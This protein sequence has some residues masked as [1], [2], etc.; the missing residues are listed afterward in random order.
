VERCG[1]ESSGSRKRPVADSCEHDNE[2][3]GSIK[4]EESLD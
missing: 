3:L 4:G 1:L 2:N